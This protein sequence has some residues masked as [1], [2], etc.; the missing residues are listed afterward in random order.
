MTASE[1]VRGLVLHLD[2]AVLAANGGVPSCKPE[3]AVQDGHFFLCLSTEA[4]SG[5][6]VPLYST[7]GEGRKRLEAPGRKGHPKWTRGI[8]HVD[9]DQEWTAP[10][11]AI[12]AAAKAGKDKSGPG[13]RNRLGVNAL[14]AIEAFLRQQ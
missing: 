10:H 11:A 6:W 4:D 12:I 14:A 8:F 2:P 7:G 13:R 3:R 5:R 1:I 9:R